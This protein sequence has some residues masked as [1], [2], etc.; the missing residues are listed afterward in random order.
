MKRP[1]ADAP[2][3]AAATASG[4]PPEAWAT[5]AA[6]PWSPSQRPVDT[7]PGLTVVTRMPRGPTSFDSAFEKFASAAFAAL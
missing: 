3:A 4:S 1:V 7:G 2:A 6:T 5:V